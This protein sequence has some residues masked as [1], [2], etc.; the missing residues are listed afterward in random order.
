MTGIDP[1]SENVAVASAHAQGD[2][3]TRGIRYEAKTAE[4][5]EARGVST[6]SEGGWFRSCRLSDGVRLAEMSNGARHVFLLYS[7]YC[8]GVVTKMRLH[9]R[10]HGTPLVICYLVA[11]SKCKRNCPV[12][13]SPCHDVEY[14]SLWSRSMQRPASCLRVFFLFNCS[15][16]RLIPSPCGCRHEEMRRI[17]SKTHQLT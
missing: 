17:L 15:S 11:A 16:F 7:Y 2:P 10:S 3:L 6:G 9:W 13:R 4:E 12:C 14:T 5:L 1:S 8:R